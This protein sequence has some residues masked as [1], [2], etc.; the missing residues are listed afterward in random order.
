MRKITYKASTDIALIKYWGK[1]DEQLRIPENDS[2]SIVID[3]IYTITTVEFKTDLDRDEVTIDGEQQLKEVNRVSKYLDRFRELANIKT[4]AKVVSESNF[5]RST[6]LS[7]TG[8]AFAALTYAATAALE[9]D[10][11]QKELSILARQASGTACRCVCGGFV[12]W[13]GG[14]SSSDSYSETIF[15]ADHWDLRDIV[16]VVD[17]KAKQISSTAGHKTAQTS[18]FY[19][20]RQKNLP[21]KMKLLQEYVEN[22][23]F[24]QLGE[25]IEAEALEF[26]S[27][28]L[29][30]QP[31]LLM[32]Q[33]GT[34]EVMKTVQALRQSGVEAYFSLN[35]GFNLHV[36]TLPEHEEVV[37]AELSKLKLVK[38]TIKSKIGQKP[39]EISQHLF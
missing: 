7:S 17:D 37:A 18:P 10:L 38:N 3:G 14:K 35:T 32:W 34:V 12:Q 30:S 11:D 5:P 28:L 4:F 16:V 15:P 33:P 23:D 27:I 25:L 1:K 29:T 24:T 8:S 2:F 39:T 13:H 36:L 19:L 26:H 21:S 20:T 22:R 9:L 6:G 31:P